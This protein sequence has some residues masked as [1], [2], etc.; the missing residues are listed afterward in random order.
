VAA[1]VDNDMAAYMDDEMASYVGIDFF[2]W[3]IY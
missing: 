3:A 2:Y 1:Y